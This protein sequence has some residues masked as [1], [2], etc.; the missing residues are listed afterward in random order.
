[1]LRK[2]D[3]LTVELQKRCRAKSVSTLFPLFLSG[4][5]NSFLGLSP[6]RSSVLPLPLREGEVPT[7]LSKCF[8]ISFP[9]ALLACRRGE[10]LPGEFA[11]VSSFSAFFL[12]GVLST[13]LLPL[14]GRELASSV[15]DLCGLMAVLGLDGV[16][17]L[18]MP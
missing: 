6:D 5:A 11:C 16:E 15:V 10:E 3:S 14:S 7:M 18:A 13:S 2:G 17:A 9:M 12:L 8:C 4:E 1:M